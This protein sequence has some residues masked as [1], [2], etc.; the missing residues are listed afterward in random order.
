M[1]H[2]II[3]VRKRRDVNIGIVIFLVILIYLLVHI[4]NYF[5]KSE[6][7]IYEVQPGKIYTTAQCDG[8]IIR[9]EELVFTES[10]GYVNYYFSEGSRVAKNSTIYSID[11]NRDIYSL[12]SGNAEEIKL[13]G[14]DLSDLKFLI[15]ENLVNASSHQ[16]ISNA[17][18]DVLTGYQRLIDAMLMEELNHITSLSL[19]IAIYTRNKSPSGTTIP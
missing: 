6:I 3:Q 5:T 1:A 2:N 19:N 12:I 18:A 13:A 11:S 7:S 14:E 9:T 4:Y 8:M 17:K 15:Q 10:A 16:E